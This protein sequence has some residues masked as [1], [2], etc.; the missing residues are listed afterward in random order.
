MDSSHHGLE[1][2][3]RMGDNWLTWAQSRTPDSSVIHRLVKEINT[4]L[5]R[6]AIPRWLS[7]ADDRELKMRGAYQ[8]GGFQAGGYDD[9]GNHAASSLFLLM[10][11]PRKYGIDA[12]SLYPRMSADSRIEYIS[13]VAM[14]SG[15]GIDNRR[16][17]CVEA[18]L[19]CLNLQ[20]K[21]RQ[22]L[23]AA[24]KHAARIWLL[25]EAMQCRAPNGVGYWVDS[26]RRA[27]LIADSFFP[28]ESEEWWQ[29]M[30]A[31]HNEKER[32]QASAQARCSFEREVQ[33]QFRALHHD[34]ETWER[35]EG[36]L[37][38]SHLATLAHV[39]SHSQ[40]ARMLAKV[41]AEDRAHRG[42]GT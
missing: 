17:N 12:P 31:W 29:P 13:P 21:L 14:S 10:L 34:I 2:A 27:K 30:L 19:N 16:G 38:R 8:T 37:C 26:D 3:A 1:L 6:F 9:Y 42:L 7:E 11:L 28:V 33:T 4:D 24:W 35:S 36:S 40:T 25:E 15:R 22:T 39:S 18:M 20:S 5:L 23:Q 32:G 41:Y